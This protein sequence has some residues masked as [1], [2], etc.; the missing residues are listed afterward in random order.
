M[1]KLLLVLIHQPLFRILQRLA[2]QGIIPNTNESG[3]YSRGWSWLLNIFFDGPLWFWLWNCGFGLSTDKHTNCSLETGRAYQGSVC[4]INGARFSL[5]PFWIFVWTH[6]R[7]EYLYCYLVCVIYCAAKEGVSQKRR[8]ILNGNNILLL[9]ENTQ[10]CIA[11]CSTLASGI[12]IAWVRC[13]IESS[14]LT[15]FYSQDLHELLWRTRHWVWNKC[16]C[17]KSV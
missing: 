7:P 11:L 14:M 15:I 6:L 17:I 1:L 9:F 3:D 10:V 2:I 5:C 13:P 4:S 8:L 12:D 16:E